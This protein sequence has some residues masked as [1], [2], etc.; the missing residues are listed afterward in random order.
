MRKSVWAIAMAAWM[1]LA[2]MSL[3]ACG[4]GAPPTEQAESAPAAAAEP[5]KMDPA[6]VKQRIDSG[7][8]FFLLD[9]RSAQELVDDGMIAGA[10]HIPIDELEARLAEV[11]KDKAIVTYCKVGGR[12]TRAAE[13]LRKAGYD[14]PIEVGGITAWKEAGYEVVHPKS[15]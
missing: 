11:P 6:A 7:E 1:S 14:E 3:A 5:T 13:T 4:G 12:A 9:V 8:D 10:V 2:W 15:E